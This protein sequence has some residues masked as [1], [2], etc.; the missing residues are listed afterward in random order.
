[1]L[2]AAENYDVDVTGI[3]LSHNQH[4]YVNKLI[5]EKGLTGRV[6]FELL[7]YRKLDESR[8][9]DKIA[10]VGMFEHVGEPSWRGIFPSCVVW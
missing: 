6:R 3:T 1:M 10:S 7:D 8:P 9:F 5:E 4:A 2:W